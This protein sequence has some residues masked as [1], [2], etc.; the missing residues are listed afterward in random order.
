ML[1]DE[2][3]GRD[4]RLRAFFPSRALQP[5]VVLVRASSLGEGF[6]ADFRLEGDLTWRPAHPATRFAWAD[7][8]R[9]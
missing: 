8:D 3:V 6:V 4:D 1:G 9:V 5:Q 2:R 7:D